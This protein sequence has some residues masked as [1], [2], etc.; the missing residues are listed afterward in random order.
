[1]AW[2]GED[3]RKHVTISGDD[4]ME[5]KVTLAEIR[6][7][8]KHI[9]EKVDNHEKTLY[10]NGTPGLKTIVTNHS[11]TLAIVTWVGSIAGGSLLTAMFAVLNK[12]FFK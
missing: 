8:Q 6:K 12:L 3:R 2:N 1:M 11:H 5:I 4:I 7:D 10:G 9:T